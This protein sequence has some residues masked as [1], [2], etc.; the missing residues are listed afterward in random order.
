MGEDRWRVTIGEIV[1]PFG[2][3]GEV[4]VRPLTDF[5]ERFQELDEVCV[6]HDRDES[7][8]LRI[9]RAWLH[10]GSVIVKLAGFEDISAAETL[11]G[12]RILIPESEVMPLPEDEYYV[13]QIIGL[14]V[15]TTEGEYLG[16]VTQVLR[17]P[18]HD[19]YV[20][21]RAMIPA[22]KEFVRDISLAEKKIVVRRIE[23]MVQ[24]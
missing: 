7:R 1:S 21:D 5:P 14:D 20:T 13:H 16:K 4:K 6:A 3:K 10:K 2:R 22:V 24:E 18:A 15:F 23:G 12:A 8:V 19:V 11:R 17:T 9:E